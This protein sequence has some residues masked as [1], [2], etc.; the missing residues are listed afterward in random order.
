VVVSVLLVD[1]GNGVVRTSFRSKAPPLGHGFSTREGHQLETGA[2]HVPDVDVAAVAEGF[3][4]GGH[5]RA[6]GARITG[7]LDEARRTVEAHLRE[8]FSQLA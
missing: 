8:V 5:R 3:G 1:R 6:A 2:T 4:G 7:S